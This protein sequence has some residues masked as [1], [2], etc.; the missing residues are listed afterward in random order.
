M[1]QGNCNY[2]FWGGEETCEEK[3]FS[4]VLENINTSAN[5]KE[6]EKQIL[7]DD[8]RNWGVFIHRLE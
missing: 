4:H 5:W 1:I 3:T 8:T 6:V 7:W 2:N